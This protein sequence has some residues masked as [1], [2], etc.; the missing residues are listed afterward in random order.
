[1]IVRCP[2]Q[3]EVKASVDEEIRRRIASGEDPG[4]A[5][6]FGGGMLMGLYRNLDRERCKLEKE[7]EPS[8]KST[9]EQKL[10]FVRW[11]KIKAGN[12]P[13]V[14]NDAYL[15]PRIK[16]VIEEQ[17]RQLQGSK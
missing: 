7:L 5:H 12:P 16:E 8:G 4:N 14:L 13:C 1:M 17:E 9:L 2:G 15:L 11:L 3:E 10:A 6:A